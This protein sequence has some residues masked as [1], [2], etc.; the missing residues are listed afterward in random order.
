MVTQDPLAH[1]NS[2]LSFVGININQVPAD[3]ATP[4][5]GPSH[6]HQMYEYPKVKGKPG[7]VGHQL[8]HGF[9]ELVVLSW[10]LRDQVQC[11]VVQTLSRPTVHCW[12]SEARRWPRRWGGLPGGEALELGLQNSCP[13]RTCGL[14]NCNQGRMRVNQ[15]RGLSQ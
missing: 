2:V 5:W 1:I 11:N 8:R 15:S 7:A 9:P 3:I 10:A 12:G 4:S 13:P 14:C 6:P